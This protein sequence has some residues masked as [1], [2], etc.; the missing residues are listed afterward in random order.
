MLFTQINME[1][2][3]QLSIELIWEDVDL[4]ELRISAQNGGYCGTAKVYFAQGDVGVLADAIRGF[5]KTV[6]Q[7][8]IFEGGSEEIG[9]LARLVFSC[10]DG[11]GHPAVTV[12]L[13]E[14]VN[15]NARP[16]LLNRVELELQFEPYAL[17]EFSRE[18][19][20]MARRATTR[21]VLRGIAA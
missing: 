5:P 4:E 17:D 11:S 8:E 2:Y 20:S 9:S 6:S 18:L 15:V 3:P 7:Q 10:T 1:G 16:L 19:E 13:A 21:A 12:S 14:S